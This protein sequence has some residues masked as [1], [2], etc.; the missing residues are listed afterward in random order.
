[1]SFIILFAYIPYYKA[2]ECLENLKKGTNF[3]NF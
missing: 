1:M 2:F 3:D